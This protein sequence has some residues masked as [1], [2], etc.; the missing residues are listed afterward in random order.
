M[1]KI[2][3]KQNLQFY[4]DFFVYLN[5]CNIKFLPQK[6][7]LS[8]QSVLLQSSLFAKVPASGFPVFNIFK[9]F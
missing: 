9:G 1:L 5:L 3:G 4:A 8:K 7:V 2:M 6:I